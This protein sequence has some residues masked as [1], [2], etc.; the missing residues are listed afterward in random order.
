MS[1]LSPRRGHWLSSTELLWI[2]LP[3]L[4]KLIL[5]NT[6]T[7]DLHRQLWAELERD[8]TVPCSAP[9][10]LTHFKPSGPSHTRQP[11]KKGNRTW[12]TALTVALLLLRKPCIQRSAGGMLSARPA[13]WSC[14]LLQIM[15]RAWDDH[16][17]RALCCTSARTSLCAA[18]NGF[19]F[20]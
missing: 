20:F 15:H 19:F 17:E 4:T 14:S 13:A 8:Q 10:A 9:P 18:G 11:T 6:V 12:L 5:H 2:H 3:G 7:C 1:Q 16:R